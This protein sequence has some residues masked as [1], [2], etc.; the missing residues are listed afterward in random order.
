MRRARKLINR[1]TKRFGKHAKPVLFAAGFGVVGLVFILATKAATPTASFEAE[2]GTKNNVSA[3]SD[4][5]AS[6]SS[7]VKFAATTPPVQQ[8]GICTGRDANGGVPAD[9]FPGAACTGVIA[10]TTLTQIGPTSSGNGWRVDKVGGQNVL[11]VTQAGTVLENISTTYYV[12]VMANNVTIKNSK[13]A[14]GGDYAMFIG[15]LPTTYGGLHLIDVELDGTSPSNSFVI[16]I[17]PSLNA[18]FTRVNVHG[19]TSSGPRLTT[20]N[21]VEDSWI[22]DFVQTPGGHLAGMSS[23]GSDHGIILRHNNIS[24]N[25]EGASSTIAL[26]RDFGVPYDVLIE[27]N[28]LNGGNYCIMAGIAASDGS[29]PPTNDIRIIDNVFGREFYPECGRLGYPV[30][31]FSRTNGTGNVASGNTWGDGAAATS[32]HKVG[33]P[34][35]L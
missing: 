6:A 19:M 24:I 35:N 33:D 1:V 14:Y 11:Y 28:L 3:V 31:Q 25:A 27:R 7:A 18:R 2:S 16:A 5:T 20:G 15:D 17:N 22:H 26:Y 9:K 8:T 34:I 32:S 10:G 13:L 21:I 30:A 4:T 29:Y 12:K 23:N